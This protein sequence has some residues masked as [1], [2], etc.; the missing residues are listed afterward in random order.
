MEG[1]ESRQEELV[2]RESE[3][4]AHATCTF[5]T[6]LNLVS[7][8]PFPFDDRQL[9]ATHA[10]L[11]GLIVQTVLREGKLRPHDHLMSHG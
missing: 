5:Q 4:P 10:Q 7:Y 8:M 11:Y 9:A 2:S 6:F 3:L 1:D